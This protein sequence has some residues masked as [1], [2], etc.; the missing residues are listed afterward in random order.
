M[1]FSTTIVLA[2]TLLVP[3]TPCASPRTQPAA[4]TVAT[5]LSHPPFMGYPLVYQGTTRASPELQGFLRSRSAAIQT[6]LLQAV[7]LRHRQFNTRHHPTQAPLLR[8]AQVLFLIRP[9]RF[10]GRQI[11]LP[12]GSGHRPSRVLCVPVVQLRNPPA[13]FSSPPD[14]FLPAHRPKQ[15]KGQQPFCRASG[16]LLRRLTHL[17]IIVRGHLLGTQ[18]CGSLPP[19]RMKGKRCVAPGCELGGERGPARGVASTFVERNLNGRKRG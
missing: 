7:L 19:G 4:S 15:E 9:T 14:R 12:F 6:Y 3:A 13:P 5:C 16:D 1:I 2:S 18:D 8:A 11:V 10:P 17:V